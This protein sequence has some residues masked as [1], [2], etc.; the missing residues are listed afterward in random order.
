[1]LTPTLTWTTAAPAISAAFL[2]SVVEVVEAFTIVLAVA[3]VRGWRPAALGAMAGLGLLALIV[4]VFGPLLGLVPL[5]L[6]QSAIGI[7]LLMFGMRWLRKAVLRAAGVIPLHDEAAA[8]EGETEAL[9]RIS[10]AAGGW[11]HV[12]VM[13]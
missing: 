9:R 1:M 7:L 8:F 5:R 2:S 12:A 4:V 3:T 6:L 13:T 10:P 11:D